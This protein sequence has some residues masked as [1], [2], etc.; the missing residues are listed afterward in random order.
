MD[1][2]NTIDEDWLDRVQ[3]VVNYALDEEMYVILNV[4]HDGGGDPDFGAW[5]RTDEAEFSDVEEK[6]ITL[7]EQIAD[8]F[9]DYDEH[10]IFESMNEVGFEDYTDLDTAYT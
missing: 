6:Y 4:H 1:E 5:I 10:L 8:R 2:N 9:K 7:R 3:E